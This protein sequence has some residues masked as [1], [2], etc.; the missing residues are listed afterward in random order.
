MKRGGYHMDQSGEQMQHMT[1]EQA[2][3]RSREQTA[4]K[5]REQQEQLQKRDE[6]LCREDQQAYQKYSDP[7]YQTYKASRKKSTARNYRDYEIYRA[8][9]E[10]EMQSL[11]GLRT[12]EADYIRQ[13][14]ALTAGEETEAAAQEQ[15]LLRICKASETDASITREDMRQLTDALYC[16]AIMQGGAEK[17]RAE[18]ERE[19][20]AA[21]R[22]IYC[23]QLS[24][25][26]RKYGRKLAKISPKEYLKRL[27][28]LE[29]DFACIRDMYA[30]IGET[31]EM[32]DKLDFYFNVWQILQSRYEAY[33]NGDEA[34][35]TAKGE[36]SQMA[37]RQYETMMKSCLEKAEQKDV[38]REVQRKKRELPEILKTTAAT[39][40]A[41]SVLLAQMEKDRREQEE[42]I[43]ASARILDKKMERI[44]EYVGYVSAKQILD[45]TK[46]QLENGTIEK[47]NAENTIR[48]AQKNIRRYEEQKDVIRTEEEML[49]AQ[50]ELDNLQRQEKRV[51]DFEITDDN[52][53]EIIHNYL[54]Q[55]RKFQTAEMDDRALLAGNPAGAVQMI[56]LCETLNHG[57][58]YLRAEQ[59]RADFQ[60]WLREAEKR[61]LKPE[62]Q[63]RYER[64]R[65]MEE[66]YREFREYMEK[67]MPSD[68]DY[69]AYI[70]RRLKELA[71]YGYSTGTA[72]N[73]RKDTREQMQEVSAGFREA[74][75]EL[76]AQKARDM[77]VSKDLFAWTKEPKKTV[78][79]M[80]RLERGL[81]KLAGMKTDAVDYYR[82]GQTP[83]QYARSECMVQLQ[84]LLAE[85]LELIRRMYHVDEKGNYVQT[86]NRREDK[87]VLEQNYA[88]LQVRYQQF[89]EDY[90]KMQSL[91]EEDLVMQ[92]RTLTDQVSGDAK[93]GAP[94][95]ETSDEY[96]GLRVAFRD[97]YT[98][99]CQSLQEGDYKDAVLVDHMAEIYECMKLLYGIKA[100][101]FQIENAELAEELNVYDDPEVLYDQLLDLKEYA[102][103]LY[104]RQIGSVSD[105]KNP[106]ANM[107]RENAGQIEN[108]RGEKVRKIRL[109]HLEV[110][111]QDEVAENQK[112]ARLLNEVG[113]ELKDR[114]QRGEIRERPGDFITYAGGLIGYPLQ[115]FNWIIR[116]KR[117]MNHGQVNYEK[118]CKK[119]D[120]LLEKMP[121]LRNSTLESYQRGDASYVP[122]VELK[123]YFTSDWKQQLKQ[124]VKLEGLLPYENKNDLYTEEY[125]TALRAIDRYRQIVG[126]VNTDTTEMEMAY[127]DT[128]QTAA[129]A[130]L[131]GNR[132]NEDGYVQANYQLLQEL[133]RQMNETLSGTLRDTMDEEEFRHICQNT[134]AY[135]EDTTYSANLEESNVREI[136]LFLHEPNINDVRQSSIGD[137]WYVSAISSVVNANPAFIRSMFQDLGDGNVLVRMFRRDPAGDPMP[138]YF[139]LRKQYETGWGNACDC[140]WVQLL[141]KAYALGGFNNKGEVKTQGNHLYNVAEELTMG[142]VPKAVFT[143]TGKEPISMDWGQRPVSLNLEDADICHGL[144]AGLDLM[145]ENGMGIVFE[146]YQRMYK[147]N[148][149]EATGKEQ[150][151]L[152]L[153]Q[154]Y[155]CLGEAIDRGELEFDFLRKREGEN[156]DA[157]IDRYKAMSEQDRAEEDR[158]NRG[159]AK[160]YYEMV[161]LR[162]LESMRLGE[163]LPF[164]ED[165]R[166]N[167][168]EQG[169]NPE[170]TEQLRRKRQAVGRVHADTE[171]PY[172]L[173]VLDMA[174]VLM[175][176]LDQG[177]TLSS[178]IPHCTNIIDYAEKDGRIFFLMRDPF[179]IYNYEYTVKEGKKQIQTESLF[180][181]I[182]EREANRHLVGAD[183]EALTQGGFRGTSWIEADDMYQTLYQAFDIRPE[184]VQIPNYRQA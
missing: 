49:A 172:K 32:A 134:I 81:Y 159:A 28:E 54:M 52:I 86:L 105:E 156:L 119:Q 7:G 113:H 171:T 124:Q 16:P 166:Q 3:Q 151:G 74:G 68:Q 1:R 77:R 84:P 146:Q 182:T 76:T 169:V 61:E 144:M 19:A 148:I 71:T 161:L 38:F 130:Y 123:K 135:V 17:E 122:P 129:K 44:Q 176:H 63:E 100:S 184:N 139:K 36:L 147:E 101:D 137:C 97:Q 87:R 27:P 173:P 155:K 21:L 143:L 62:E 178:I 89:Y 110:K 24:G 30:V 158:Q 94:S 80:V 41:A 23:R 152:S 51:V 179:N 150:K 45:R 128:F 20:K 39:R 35:I 153:R 82:L 10:Q 42:Q 14:R 88:D 106:Y 69:T 167:Y 132:E 96:L 53:G 140:V 91:K 64:T 57:H 9:K 116:D 6:K 104:Y 181:V 103:G 22:E 177:A 12:Q 25:L 117:T 112:K 18:Y 56:K 163:E 90:Q 180:Q 31:D 5:N 66:E 127:L 15:I 125:E 79:E 149:D 92:I 111:L 43:E 47:E 141:E 83:L 50:A 59:K 157:Y 131:D 170:R 183:R 72:V 65:K 142:A 98:Q 46:E 75:E 126:I 40:N 115:F 164:T 85:A 4:Q 93:Y 2:M 48:I 175:E 8:V 121:E 120:E 95:P 78:Q 165:Q 60:Q 70:K 11:Y 133:L 73:Q 138:V 13:T 99:L 37:G 107:D 58:L 34:Q 26:D 160:A 33:V 55:A 108:E 136:P 29:Q 102:V 118:A 168:R 154:L 162:N 114:M 174:Q 109:H 67:Q 145:E